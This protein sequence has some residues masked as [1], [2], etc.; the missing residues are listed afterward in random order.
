V[1]VIFRTL[2][3]LLNDITR[4]EWEDIKS[5]I[6]AQRKWIEVDNGR[7]IEFLVIVRSRNEFVFSIIDLESKKQHPEAHFHITALLKDGIIQ[8]FHIRTRMIPTDL[9]GDPYVASVIDTKLANK[10]RSGSDLIPEEQSRFESI[11]IP[12]SKWSGKELLKRMLDFFGDYAK[13]LE[14]DYMTGNHLM[15]VNK[16]ILQHGLPLPDV[17]VAKGPEYSESG[18]TSASDS[19]MAESSIR[20]AIKNGMWHGVVLRKLGIDYRVQLDKFY[21]KNRKV[22]RIAFKLIFGMKDVNLAKLHKAGE[23]R[24]VKMHEEGQFNSADEKIL[25]RIEQKAAGN[26]REIEKRIEKK[27]REDELKI[28]R[29]ISKKMKEKAESVA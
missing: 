3:D 11:R 27:A 9:L 15:A 23:G 8:D 29:R 24:I 22:R 18:L 20:E 10:I 14:E 4:K 2:K 5:G 7:Y 28:L 21:I 12:K 1:K 17:T 19:L 6:P 13:A 26:E 16:Y 25:K